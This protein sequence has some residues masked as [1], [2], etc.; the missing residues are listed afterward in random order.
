VWLLHIPAR[1]QVALPETLHLVIPAIKKEF[2]EFCVNFTPPT[3]K[4]S[5]VFAANISIQG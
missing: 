1:R 3:G 2:A 4:K 5:S